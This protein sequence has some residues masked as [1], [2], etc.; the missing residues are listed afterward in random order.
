MKKHYLI[1][2]AL[3]VGGVGCK[4]AQTV[5][6][7]GEN[8]TVYQ[9]ENGVP[10][11]VPMY[12]PFALKSDLLTKLSVNNQKA[13]GLL[14][15]AAQEMD[16]VFWIQTYGDRSALNTY[17]D[18]ALKAYI[19]V[20]YGPWDFLNANKP[21]LTGVGVKPEGANYYP[22]DM[23][24]AEFEAAAEQNPALKSAY[25]MVR[26]NATGKLEAIPFS[27]FFKP[28]MERA[29]Q[30]LRAAA[31]LTDD[32]GLRQY[33]TL[34]ADALL[35]NEYQASDFAW[36][37]MKSTPID[38]VI[39]PIETYEDGLFGYKAGAESYVLL[40]DMAWSQRLSRY[41]ALLPMLQT[42]L[43]VPDA[44]KTE[45]P[46][47]D[48]DLNA[49]DVVYVTGDAN[50]GS[51]TIAI[52]LPNDEEVQLKKG[53]R[54]LQLKNAM[55][56]KFDHMMMPITNLLIAPDQRA[57][58][59]FDAFFGTTMFHEVAH[60][61]GIKNTING[62]G[63]VRAN[64]KEQASWL[65]E[66]K[67]DI[68]GLCMIQKLIET[69]ELKDVPLNDYYVTF[70]ASI[71]RSIRFGTGSAHGKAN[72]VR[73]NYFRERGVFNRDAATGTYRVDFGKLRAA[74]NELSDKILQLQGNGDYD[75]VKQ[76]WQQY[77]VADPVLKGDLERLANA[78]IPVDI[79]F[80]QGKS[81]LG[82]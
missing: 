35:S 25:T 10:T 42:G 43:P 69:G 68:L 26:R 82:L 54:R 71:F 74:V 36:M 62:K 81:V 48:S 61:L 15:E 75:G 39:G 78:H 4:H 79:I 3:L 12:V 77:G 13:V 1:L 63:T 5:T 32:A 18:P 44:Y 72:L 31:A 58:V 34:R 40:K 55:K 59:S 22:K 29:A 73:F 28:Q 6:A 11:Q 76:F 30:K 67:A 21:F 2:L 38:L 19:A 45:S 49:Y 51:K 46:G 37:D 60:G 52:N 41:A 80:E 33:L 64:L 14:I 70:C 24:K 56:A 27:T 66:G 57:N 7:T 20:N 23:T 9:I 17:Q 65:E 8:G 53:T 47:T 16:D 50:S